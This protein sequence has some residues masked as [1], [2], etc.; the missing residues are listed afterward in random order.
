MARLLGPDPTSRRVALLADRG[1]YEFAYQFA[2]VYTDAAATQLADIAA[3]DGTSTLGASISGSRVQ[4]S[5]TSRLP[6]FWF[7]DGV[8]TLYVQP[9]GGPVVQV[10]ADYDARLDA[11]ASGA[12]VFNVL[13]YGAKGDGSTDDT[14]AINACIAAAY[15]AGVAN[16]TYYAEIFFPPARYKV[17]GALTQGGSTLGNALIPLPVVSATSQKFTL[18][19]RGTESAAGMWHWQQTTVQTGCAALVTTVTGTNHGTYGEASVI[20]GPTPAQGYGRGGTFSNLYVVIDGLHI[21]VPTDPHICG[22]D[23]AGVANDDVRDL[24][25]KV[26]ATPATVTL[27]TQSWQFGLRQP[28]N[29]NNDLCLIGTYTTEGM[30]YGVVTNEHTVARNIAAIYCLAGVEHG[31]GGDTAHGALIDYLSVESCNV[32]L[33]AIS[34]GFP[35]KIDVRLLDWEGGTGAFAGF[36]VVNDSTDRLLGSVRVTT[37]GTATHLQSGTGSFHVNGGANFRVYDDTRQHGAATAPAVPA[38]TVALKNPFYR[39]AAVNITGGTVTVIA[40]DGVTT[41]LTSGTVVLPTGKNITLTYSAA[42]TWV[43]TVL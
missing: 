12:G 6:Q 38:T 15:N 22:V 35:N 9:L 8:D 28:D 11:A 5:A 36:A 3:Y 25:V 39:D 34:G 40:V 24:S 14:S 41:G 31:R 10:N 29:D 13:N 33:G 43:W 27:A 23:L 42:P 4:L 26:N 16:G 20:G 32:G 30:N 19:L 37:V 17:D 2:R 21:V 18:V 1:P 7:P